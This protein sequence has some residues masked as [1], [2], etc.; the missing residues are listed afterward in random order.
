MQD[1]G[2][3][4]MNEDL[5]TI[6]NL[7]TQF[8]LRKGIVKAADGVSLKIRKGEILGLVG[9]SGSGKT[10]TSLS[11]V[12][13]VPNPGRITGGSIIFKGENLLEK[14]DLEM[15]KIRGKEISLIFQD[16]MT[17]LNPVFKVGDQIMEKIR[18]HQKVNKTE[19]R[20]ETIELMKKVGIPSAE[21]RINDYPHVFSGGLRQRIMIAIALAGHPSLIIADEPTTSLDVTIG[22]QVLDLMKGLKKE[23]GTSILLITHN[24]GIIAQM[25][26]K[27]AVMYA[28]MV[29][30]Y[31]DVFT[32][33]RE[34]K[35]PY[36]EGLLLSTP[37]PNLSQQQ[38]HPIPG[39][40]PDLI[41]LPSS[42]PFNPRCAK[43]IKVCSERIPEMTQISKDHFVRCFL[44][45]E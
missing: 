25:A 35:H 2:A 42:C 4:Q 41:N 18:A 5:L 39:L 33:F 16:P 34:H 9:E 10:M 29:V 26:N 12:R 44:Y 7:K 32:I 14:T 20:K 28:G 27:V 6:K 36:T 21:Y 3:E 23:I 15:R 38:L 45:G 22:A 30:E 31:S 37:N 40:V 17:S 11:I 19:A 43:K 8:H 1:H 24:L 13:L